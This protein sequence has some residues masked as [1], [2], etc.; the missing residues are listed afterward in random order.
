MSR[1]TFPFAA[2]MEHAPQYF[3]GDPSINQEFGL[4]I[5]DNEPSAKSF[6]EC[7][8]VTTKAVYRW[9][10]PGARIEPE[11]ADR[12]AVALNTLPHLIWPEEWD[13]YLLDSLERTCRLCKEPKPL[14]PEH[15]SPMKGRDL[16]YRYDCRPCENE[17]VQARRRKKKNAA[18]A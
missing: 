8:G 2:V 13:K 18:K 16:K 14:D 17:A 4:G 15:F 12:V 3:Q 10:K 6:A 5:P 7:V 11:M 1:Q 9:M